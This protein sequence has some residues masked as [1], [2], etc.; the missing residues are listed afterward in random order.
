MV[1]CVRRH[2]SWHLVVGGLIAHM[3]D[4]KGCVT[5]MTYTVTQG[6]GCRGGGCEGCHAH[7]ASGHREGRPG[8]LGSWVHTSE[9]L[10]GGV[11]EGWQGARQRD[12]RGR[13]RGTA[14]ATSEGWQGLHQRD[15]RGWT[16]GTG[17]PWELVGCL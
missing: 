8:G 15:D 2:C 17:G 7:S 9:Q 4:G 11:S 10:A 12:S 14:G 3:V 6:L 16:D 1:H 5:V 13:V